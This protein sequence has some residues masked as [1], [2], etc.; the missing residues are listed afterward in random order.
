MEGTFD[1][2]NGLIG[3]VKGLLNTAVSQAMPA[4]FGG[5]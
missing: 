3:V 5:K 2:G 4:S 1:L